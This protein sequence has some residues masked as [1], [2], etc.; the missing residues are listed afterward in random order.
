[1]CRAAL[2]A[3][4]VDFYSNDLLLGHLACKQSAPWMFVE[5]WRDNLEKLAG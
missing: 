5:V 3:S 4:A 1:M 2:I